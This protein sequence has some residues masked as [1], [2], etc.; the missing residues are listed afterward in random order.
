MS[1][2]GQ[3]QTLWRV[4]GGRL[5]WA[6]SRH[7]GYL[8]SFRQRAGDFAGA[9]DDELRRWA[10]GPSTRFFKVSIPIGPLTIGSV[11]GNF[12]MNGCLTGNM[13]TASRRIA[14]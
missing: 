4:I 6:N 7:G 2:P 9:F 14:R 13:N 8:F 1:A 5:L 3:K 12:V 10:A 11:T